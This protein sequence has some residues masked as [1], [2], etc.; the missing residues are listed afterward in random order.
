MSASLS[1]SIWER[2]GSSHS[3][4]KNLF[5]ALLC[6][7]TTLGIGTSMVSAYLAQDWQ[8]SI[9]AVLGLFVVSIAGCFLSAKSDN[10]VFSLLGYGMIAVPLGLM[11]GP[12]F[13]IYTSASIVKIFGVTTGLVV[14]LGV[15]GAIYPKSLESWGIFLFGALI[16][17]L[18]G[19]IG[20]S[21]AGAFGAPIQ[22]AM[23]FLDWIG[24]F[25]FSAYVVFDLNRAM[26]VE[27]TVDNSIDCAVAIYLDW[28]NLFIRLLSLF[29]A[30]KD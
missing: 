20:V 27:R 26:R 7:W 13:A 6:F 25:L 17:L 21:I 28:F 22:G 10:P 16:L 15:I 9:W 4:S 14:V 24:V 5:V 2:Q 29:G 3:L 8:L 18:L 1:A 11:A 30:K 19:S 12:I 23:T